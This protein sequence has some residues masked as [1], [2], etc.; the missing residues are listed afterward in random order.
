MS[1]KRHIA[2]TTESEAALDT[3]Q[4]MEQQCMNEG[5]DMGAPV[6]AFGCGV[7]T[8]VGREMRTP[9]DRMFFAGTEMPMRWKGYMDGAGEAGQTAA[10]DVGKLL[11][12]SIDSELP[13]SHL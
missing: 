10:K 3:V 7:I 5:F 6:L 11:E 8:S 2:K 1:V 4:V 13:R 9:H 12:L